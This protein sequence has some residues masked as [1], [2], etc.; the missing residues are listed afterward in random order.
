VDGELHRKSKQPALTSH[1][2]IG[3][4][5]VTS[6]FRY[7]FR[8]CGVIK[9]QESRSRVAVSGFSLGFHKDRMGLWS[10]R[11][12]RNREPEQVTPGRMPAHKAAGNIFQPAD[13][14]RY[15]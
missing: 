14:L 12:E 5:R 10:L 6:S 7:Q 9:C 8:Y 11:P 4:N 15:F 3:R 2:W 13:A 1:V